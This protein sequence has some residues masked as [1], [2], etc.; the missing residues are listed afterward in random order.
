[1]LDTY[2]VLDLTDER[3]EIGPM[4]LGDLGADVIRVE[5]HGGSSSREKG[6]FFTSE[7]GNQ[8]SLSF[9]AFNRNKRSIVLDADAPDDR[10]VLEALIT[11]ADFIFESW[12][13]SS[14]Q[15][16][17]FTFDDVKRINPRIIQVCI[18]AFGADGPHS[19]LRG[20]DLVVAAMGGPVSLQGIV[21]RAPVRVTVPQVWRHAGVEAAAGS[22]AALYSDIEQPLVPVLQRIEHRGVLLD[23][24]LLAEQSRELTK[25]TKALEKKVH[26]EAGRD[27][28]L[29]SPKQ[30][31]EVLF[32]ELELPIIR[33]TRKGQP[34]TAED[35]LQELAEEY[36]LPQLIL[37]YRA[38]S[39]L[40]STYTDRLPQQICERTGR[41]HTS[42]H[43][44][45]TATGRL[46]SSNPN[47]QNI[48]IRSEEG[49]RIRQAFVAPEG[50]IRQ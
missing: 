15:A 39:K 16:H 44:A 18:S 26:K 47:L 22:L 40:K 36:L 6:P 23:E 1:M 24:K 50:R 10:K 3:G 33:K 19:D 20:N 38:L 2:I 32:D 30:L 8:Q 14:L 49:R 11:K 5:P 25:K 17:G 34:S 4:L 13:D 37:D 48:P 42:Y 46:S 43:Q 27:F 35:V 9:A 28:N 41:V 12:P 45:V 31:Q 21:G 29:S 7:S